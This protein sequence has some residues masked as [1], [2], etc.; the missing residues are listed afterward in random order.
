MTGRVLKTLLFI[1]G[2]KGGFYVVYWYNTD[3]IVASDNLKGRQNTQQTQLVRVI[4]R[5]S[6]CQKFKSVSWIL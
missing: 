1:K 6:N 5:K 4:A 2:W 3:A